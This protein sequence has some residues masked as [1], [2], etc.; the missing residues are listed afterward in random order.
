MATIASDA[1][2]AMRAGLIDR[3]N[4]AGFVF[5]AA[6]AAYTIVHALGGDENSCAKEPCAGQPQ[7]EP[8]NYQW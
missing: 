1:H 4:L 6:M 8:E 5:L 2:P 3:N 7:P